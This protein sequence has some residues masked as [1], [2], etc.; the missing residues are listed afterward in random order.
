M[1]DLLIKNK[2]IAEPLDAKARLGLLDSSETALK[3]SVSRKLASASTASIGTQS[4]REFQ[5]KEA[6][7]TMATANNV[8]GV[9]LGNGDTQTRTVRLRGSAERLGRDFFRVLPGHQGSSNIEMNSGS[10]NVSFNVYVD[11]NFNKQVDAGEKIVSSARSIKLEGVRDQ[12]FFVE[13]VGGLSTTNYAVDVKVNAAVGNESEPN[14]IFSQAKDVGN[15]VAKRAYK[16]A[17]GGQTSISQD[18]HDWYKFTI[19][20]TRQVS[21]SLS[22]F[23]FDRNAGANL[24]LRRDSTGDGNPNQIIAESR[25]PSGSFTS[26]NIQRTLAAGTYFVQASA[27]KGLVNYNLNFSAV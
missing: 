14:N 8:G 23:N 15:I 7:N 4:I 24:F 3:A 22:D 9:L 25:T 21:I 2:T 26:H 1:S 18:P 11:A 20:S 17:I 16:G 12:E 6:N 10:S 5:E 27:V 19:G 13:V